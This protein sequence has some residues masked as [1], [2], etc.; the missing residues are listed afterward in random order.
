MTGLIVVMTHR[1][2]AAQPARLSDEPFPEPREAALGGL[3][4]SLRW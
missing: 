1:V 3:I 2:E 4:S